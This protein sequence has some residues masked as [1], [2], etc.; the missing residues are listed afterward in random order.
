MKV[1]FTHIKSTFSDGT[2]QTYWNTFIST[3]QSTI[4][5]ADLQSIEG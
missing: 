5:E 3:I 1:R 2:E 4:A